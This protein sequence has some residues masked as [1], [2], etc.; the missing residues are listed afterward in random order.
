M[1]EVI[2][3]HRVISSCPHGHSALLTDTR[4]ALSIGQLCDEYT[5]LL[6]RLFASLLDVAKQPELLTIA[7]RCCL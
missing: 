2:E 7:S 6:V 3:R 4:C 1:F 5:G